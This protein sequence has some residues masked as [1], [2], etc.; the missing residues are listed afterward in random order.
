MKRSRLTQEGES[1]SESISRKI[2]ELGDWR[3]KTLGRIR[4][5]VKEASPGIVEEWK[6]GTPV[7]SQDGIVCTGEVYKSVVKMTF[8]KG[9]FL[10]DPAGLFNSSLGGNTRRAIDIGEG[11]N[12]NV[13]ALKALIAA[14][15]ALN[16]SGRKVARPK[17]GGR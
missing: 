9:A 7:W 17:R 16:A 4:A 14:A 11:E 2:A 13:R 8:A 12:I 3:G 15:V 10:K 5:L 1:A 6:W